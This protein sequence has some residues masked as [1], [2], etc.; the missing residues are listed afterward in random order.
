[1]DALDGSP[2]I[3]WQ[4]EQVGTRASNGAYKLRKIR[5]VA[6]GGS[7]P[8]LG[9]GHNGQAAVA[10]LH[11]TGFP[12]GNGV[13]LAIRECDAAGGIDQYRLVLHRFRSVAL[14]RAHAHREID[15]LAGGKSSRT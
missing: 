7:H 9:G 6:N 1:M 8:P 14:H 13:A 4:E 2:V 10:G 12:A 3:S 5:I 11:D 15:L